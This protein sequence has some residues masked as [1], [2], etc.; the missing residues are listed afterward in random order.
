M[1]VISVPEVHTEVCQCCPNM[2]YLTCPPA[3]ANSF[4]EESEQRSQS[5]PMY[6]ITGTR[7]GEGHEL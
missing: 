5:S 6:Q 4:S 2:L 7:E 3:G 1:S